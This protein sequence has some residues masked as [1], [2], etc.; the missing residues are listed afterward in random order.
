MVRIDTYKRIVSN[1][2]RALLTIKQILS[3][4]IITKADILETIRGNKNKR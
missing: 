1:E 2:S 4:I 3:C